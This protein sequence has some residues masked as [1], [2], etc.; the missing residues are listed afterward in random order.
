MDVHQEQIFLQKD[1]Q[2]APDK[3]DWWTRSFPFGAWCLFRDTNMESPENGDLE[4]VADPKKYFQ[5]PGFLKFQGKHVIFRGW[6]FSFP[7][8]PIPSR[9]LTYPPKMAF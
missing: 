1:K 6:K 3:N 8:S 5:V 2:F 9:E 4:D 7:K